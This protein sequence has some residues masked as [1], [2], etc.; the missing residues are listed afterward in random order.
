MELIWANKDKSL[1]SK[2][3]GGYEWVEPDDPRILP[4]DGFQLVKTVGEPVGEALGNLLI[5][6]SCLIALRTLAEVSPYKEAYAGKVKL[7]YLDPPFNAGGGASDYPDLISH[8]A[9]LSLFR[10]TMLASKAL[11]DPDGSVWV[12]LD[13]VEQHR[14]RVIMDEVYGEE[15]FVATLIWENFWKVHAHHALSRTHN[16]I[17]IYAPAGEKCWAQVRNLLGGPG[18]EGDLL[19]RTL[20]HSMDVGNFSEAKAEANE[21]FPG[22]DTFSTPKPERLLARIIHV[23]T[24]PG[25]LVIDPYAGSGTTAAVAHK[26]GR[27]WVTIDREQRTIES[28]TLP[29]LEKVV[30]GADQGG[31]SE[32][33]G[34]VGGG[35]FSYVRTALDEGDTE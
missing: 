14:A 11:L 3:D 17:H 13:D 30:S 8:E 22:E 23:A 32:E 7:I 27:A 24:N 33:L 12:H 6:G 4:G 15:A 21:L 29:R 20:W 35:S 2:A 28:Y 25:D 1:L 19:P 34:W 5:N 10:E 31:V 18:S 9:W 26:M 16:Y